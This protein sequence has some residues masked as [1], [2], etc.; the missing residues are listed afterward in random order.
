MKSLLFGAALSVSVIASAQNSSWIATDMNGVTRNIGNNLAA[1]KTVLVDISAHWC[2]PCWAWHN[3][4][5]MEKLYHE[6]G[7]E[8]TD[9]IRIYFVDGDPASSVALL[10]GASGSQGDWTAGT[11]YPIIGPNGE[12]NTLATLYGISAYP[13]LF[14]H[15]PGST[16]GVEIQR[17]AT[18]EQFLSS[19]RTGCPAAF[20]NGAIDAH[21]LEVENTELCPGEHPVADVFNQGTSAL[22]SATLTLRENGNVVETKNWT[23]NIAA[24][25]HS[26]VSFD[27]TTVAGTAT[28]EAEVSA[29]NGG[30]DANPLGNIQAESFSMAPE[31]PSTLVSLELKTDNYGSETGWKLKDGNGAVVQQVAA[32]TY[33]DGSSS[34]HN[35][36]WSLNPSECYTFEI[37]DAYGDGICCSYGTGYYKLK[38]TWGTAVVFQQG[39]QF[40]GVEDKGF[41]TPATVGVQENSLNNGLSIYPNPTSGIVNL[42]FAEN[43]TATVDV[44]NVLGERVMTSTFNT[45]GVRSIDL[46]ALNNGVYYLNVTAG[47]L[48][49]TRKITLSK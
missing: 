7:P 46:G 6:F 49:A 25:Q 21:L 36:S 29:P 35:Y 14:M 47:S 9:D 28:Y 27:N 38:N 42:E 26:V 1:G 2:G 16:T 45:N 11:P 13:T 41:D 5:I 24:F 18:W 48:T 40:G 30:V 20:A 8:G 31:A 39:A 10:E 44:F 43:T 3:S 22:T 32:G 23:G 4:G 33:A 37:T 12:G 17:T 15:C 19:W 34:V